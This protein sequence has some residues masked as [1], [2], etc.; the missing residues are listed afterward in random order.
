MKREDKLVENQSSDQQNVVDRGEKKIAVNPN[1][2]ANE[3]LPE[4]NK[5]EQKSTTGSEI[6]DG[7]AG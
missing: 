6:T 7:E 1:P 5:Q 2:R 4:E 3:N